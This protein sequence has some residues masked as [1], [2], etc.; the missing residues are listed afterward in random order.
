M[1]REQRRAELQQQA[2]FAYLS[3]HAILAEHKPNTP[4]PPN[5]DDMIEEILDCEFPAERVKA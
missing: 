3:V 4:L 5:I 1:T 2:K